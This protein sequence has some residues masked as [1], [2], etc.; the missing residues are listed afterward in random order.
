MGPSAHLWGQVGGGC[1][2]IF[3]RVVWGLGARGLAFRWKCFSPGTKSDHSPWPARPHY[4]FLKQHLSVANS[5][6][7]S[8]NACSRCLFGALVRCQFLL[9][10]LWLVFSGVEQSTSDEVLIVPLRPVLLESR[11]QSSLLISCSLGSR[12]IP[13]SPLVC[14]RTPL[15]SISL[16]GCHVAQCGGAVNSWCCVFGHLGHPRDF[17][18]LSQATRTVIIRSPFRAW[19]NL[20]WRH[21]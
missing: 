3:I 18:A 21:D 19:F 6:M 8:V 1:Y 10:V 4:S 7:S 17:I 2:L 16:P 9:T 20:P 13:S 14:Q 11:I 12:L 5:V 15:S